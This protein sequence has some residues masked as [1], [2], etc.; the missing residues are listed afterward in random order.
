LSLELLLRK[1]E[2]RQSKRL[3]LLS[4]PSQLR[5]PTSRCAVRRVYK[6]YR[7]DPKLETLNLILRSNETLA[8]QQSINQHIIK[9]LEYTIDWEKK[10]RQRGKRLNLLSEEEIGPQF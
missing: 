8:A 7:K 5:T 9:G 3:S 10:K 6:A 1:L 2:R 4:S